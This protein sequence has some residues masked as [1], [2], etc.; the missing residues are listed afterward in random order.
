MVLQAER[1]VCTNANEEK[2]S[3]ATLRAV[4][5]SLSLRAM[6]IGNRIAHETSQ[7]FLK[8]FCKPCLRV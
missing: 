1:I 3:V 7:V 2:K 5:N 6:S 8:G 4:R